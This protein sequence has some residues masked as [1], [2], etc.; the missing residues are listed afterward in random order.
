MLRAP[1]TGGRLLCEGTRRVLL[2]R[3]QRRIALPSRAVAQLGANA[4]HDYW[5]TAI[6]RAQRSKLR[7]SMNAKNPVHRLA[8]R[9]LA[10]RQ[11]RPRTRKN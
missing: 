9:R 2:I 4:L 8:R 5:R 10:A 11:S 7:V 3:G 6:G 1:G